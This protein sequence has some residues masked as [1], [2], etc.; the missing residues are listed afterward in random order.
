MGLWRHGGVMRRKAGALSSIRVG[1]GKD[2]SVHTR[3][4][5]ERC[6][7]W[8]RRPSSE[9]G[10][11]PAPSAQCPQRSNG[12]SLCSMSGMSGMEAAA[13]SGATA[14]E[15]GASSGGMAAT[16]APAGP[17]TLAVSAGAGVWAGR[18]LGRRC[19]CASNCLTMACSLFARRDTRWRFRKLGKGISIT[20]QRNKNPVAGG[21]ERVLSEFDFSEALPVM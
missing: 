6:L 20:L 5:I 7:W 13:V 11:L 17:A 2:E 3:R 21:D 8:R 19:G 18:A 1:Q 14:D 12:E 15:V 9:P 16:S 10:Y 4:L